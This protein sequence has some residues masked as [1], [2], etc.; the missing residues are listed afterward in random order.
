MRRK[1]SEKKKLK[2]KLLHKYRLV[3]L[4]E[5][6]FEERLAVKLTRLNVFVIS[7]LVAVFLVAITAVIIAFTP[8]REY[9]PGYSSTS[10]Q[11]QAMTLD[12][13][14]DSL[15][16]VINRNDVYIN[17]VKSVLRGEVSA[18]E[19][20]KDS[21]YKAA[22]SDA[23][24]LDLKPSQADSILREKINNEDKYNLFDTATSITNFVFF[25]PVNGSLSAGFDPNETHFAVDI[26]VP[27]NT[28]VKATAD[29]RVIFSSWTSDTGYV[30]IIDH[31]DELISVYKHNSSLTK[32][33]GDFVKSREV[34][35]VSGAS[36]ELSTGPHLHFELWY[37]GTPLNPSTFIDF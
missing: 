10:L 27:K 31:G 1:N 29:G 34:I 8:L 9:I 28:P 13:K 6:T 35:A 2:K 12:F 15:L 23:A 7:F 18:V 11:K 22:Q 24:I 17:S 20:N 33:Q 30:I 32:T 16:N 37:N 4:N 19:I 14:T 26:V 5:D 25:P 3:V 36:G 21:I